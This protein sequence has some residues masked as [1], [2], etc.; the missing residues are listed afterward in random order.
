MREVGRA[1]GKEKEDES[2]ESG[3]SVSDAFMP[4]Q[5]NHR[6]TNARAGIGRV[7]NIRKILMDLAFR[8]AGNSLISLTVP[9]SY[10]VAAKV[11]HFVHSQNLFVAFC[12]EWY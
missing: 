7:H 11:W 4:S 1:G 8:L 6:E 5:C 9:S 2:S 12:T 3:N 10:R